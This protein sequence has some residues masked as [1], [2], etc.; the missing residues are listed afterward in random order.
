ML[1]IFNGVQIPSGIFFQAIG[2]SIKSVILSLSRQIALLIPAMII[3]GKLYGIHGIL[4]AGPVADAISFF[5]A[6]ILLIQEIKS[7]GKKSNIDTML[8]VDD[9]GIDNKLTKHVVITIAREYGSGGRYIGRLVADKL[10]IKCYDKD[11]VIALSNQTGLSEEYIENNEQKRNIMDALNNG[12]YFSLS[13][14]DELFVEESKLIKELAKKE[15]CVIIGRCSDFILKD[16]SNI[17]NIF[18]YSDMEDKI[19][20]AVERYGINEKD[21]EKEIK[22]IDKQRGNHYK[23][24]TGKK[25][26]ET[27]NYDFCLNSDLLGVEKTADLI[28]NIAL[29]Y[30][31]Q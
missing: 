23:H 31:E 27:Q 20:R 1:C 9:T 28:C 10:G 16:N 5:I 15:S 21:A 12:Y 30:T 22:N 13:N 7:L 4:Y 6:V 29:Q 8:L 3:L 24:Y 18:I 17:I 2:K 11:L 19:H 14:S 26:G 25:W